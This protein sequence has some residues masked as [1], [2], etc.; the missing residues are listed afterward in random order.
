MSLRSLRM[1]FT[2]RIG[3]Q[4]TEDAYHN[5]ILEIVNAIKNRAIR[6]PEALPGYAMTIARRQVFLHIREMSRD[7]RTADVETVVVRCAPAESPEHLALNLERQAI[8]E[9][10]L[11]ALPPRDREVLVLFYLHGK[12]P[13]EI[14][15]ALN[16]T[17]TQFRLIKSRA[18]A[19]YAEL[20]QQ[21]MTRAVRSRKPELTDYSVMSLHA[22]A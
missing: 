20:V 1:F 13:E 16:L 18:K 5:L 22:I 3:P 12:S 2:R 19:R 15:T 14:C 21:A 8:A 10:V 7:R 11:M 4:R 9:R 6:N 17:S